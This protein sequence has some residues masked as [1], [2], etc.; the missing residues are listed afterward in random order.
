[1]AA[2]FDF[3]NHPIAANALHCSR[4]PELDIAGERREAIGQHRR[5]RIQ[6]FQI[7]RTAIHGCP[8]LHLRQHWVM[9]DL[10]ERRAFR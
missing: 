2:M 8:M 5:R 10:F 4:R 9:L 3:L 1:M 7:A 6:A